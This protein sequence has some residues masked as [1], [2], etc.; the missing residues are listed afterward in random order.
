MENGERSLFFDDRAMA[1]AS[2]YRAVK[3]I[4]DAESL[5]RA[6][7]F[8][9]GIAVAKLGKH[10]IVADDPRE[11]LSDAYN[12]LAIALTKVEDLNHKSA[13]IT[14]TGETE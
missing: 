4:A 9:I 3:E 10:Q 2:L 8:D 1:F 6:A 14:K 11:P 13:T 7:N 12:K 5:L